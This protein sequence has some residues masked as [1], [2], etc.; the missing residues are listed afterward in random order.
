MPFR[1]VLRDCCSIQVELGHVINCTVMVLD[2]LDKPLLVSSLELLNLTPR[3][4]RDLL[5]V[6]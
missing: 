1:V 6:K 3:L 5:T 2:E 4:S